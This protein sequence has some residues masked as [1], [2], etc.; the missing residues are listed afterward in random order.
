[1]FSVASEINFMI[2]WWTKLRHVL[3]KCADFLQSE[4]AN[5]FCPTP[6]RLQFAG[7]KP[8]LNKLKSILLQNSQFHVPSFP[9]LFLQISLL[10]SFV[11]IRILIFRMYSIWENFKNC[12]NK[13]FS[14]LKF[15]NFSAFSL[16]FTNVSL[17]H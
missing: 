10:Q 3:F 16:K 1:M 8:L 17:N 12:W 11:L 6:C 14:D 7:V 2:L 5:M 15:W 9:N 13:L 4:K